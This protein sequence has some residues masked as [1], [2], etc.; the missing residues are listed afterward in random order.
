MTFDKCSQHE[1]LACLDI[2]TVPD[3]DFLPPRWP[4]TWFMTS[5]L[6]GA[7]FWTK[8]N[9]ALERLVHPLALTLALGRVAY[10]ASLL[11][12]MI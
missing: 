11:L 9:E 6:C 7:S 8:R 4:A 2:E 12:V 1:H 10:Q 3:R 5:A